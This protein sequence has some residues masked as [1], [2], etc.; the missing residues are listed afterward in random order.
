[1]SVLVYTLSMPGRN[2]WNGRWSGE[3][4]IYAITR[5][6][7]N[8]KKAR[9][10]ADAILAG[11]RYSYRWPDGWCAAI[12]VSEVSAR[13]AAAIRRKSAGFCGYGWMVQSI[14]ADGDIYGPDQ[15]KPETAHP[16]QQS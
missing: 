12:S 4:R 2:S 14:E 1:M 11:R 3:D 15:P 16:E 13:E 9:E 5:P 6:I 7:R 8:S 10:K